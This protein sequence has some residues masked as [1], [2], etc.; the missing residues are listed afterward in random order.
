MP[1]P[2]AATT[3][4]GEIAEKYSTARGSKLSMKELAARAGVSTRMIVRLESSSVLEKDLETARKPEKKRFRRALVRVMLQLASALDF[5]GKQIV[6]RADL[7]LRDDELDELAARANLRQRTFATAFASES[8]RIG[9]I[10]RSVL[11]GHEEKRTRLRTRKNK[12]GRSP[13]NSAY[14]PFGLFAKPSP[15]GGPPTGLLIDLVNLVLGSLDSGIRTDWHMEKN[16][17]ELLLSPTKPGEETPSIVVGF[18]RQLQREFG[19]G[20]WRLVPVPGFRIRQVFLVQRRAEKEKELRWDNLFDA[21]I[22]NRHFYVLRHSVAE[23]YLAGLWGCDVKYLPVAGERSRLD[24]A[25][26]KVFDSDSKAIVVVDEVTFAK[27]RDELRGHD[28]VDLAAAALPEAVPAY[29]LG[30]AVPANQGT[31]AHFIER[32]FNE[33]L[34]TRHAGVT[35]QHYGRFLALATVEHGEMEHTLDDWLTGVG[36]TDTAPSYLQ[37]HQS[38]SWNFPEGFWKLLERATGRGIE[39]ELH[40]QKGSR[41]ATKVTA[42]QIEAAARR[43]AE[44]VLIAD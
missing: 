18:L 15:R 19:F 26:K 24:A 13:I 7:H 38:G 33:E 36:P 35:A 30:I 39:K 32:V 1:K 4:A 10:Q 43:L 16:Y 20:L 5:D 22:K 42:A 17:A 8:D 3:T 40:A 23:N 29:E 12:D 31:L 9:Q 14:F 25:C 41:S 21:N 37:V 34:F 44:W 11:R 28:L 27:L 2:S 6:K